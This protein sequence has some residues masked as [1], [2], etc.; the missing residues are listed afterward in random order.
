[1]RGGQAGGLLQA[2]ALPGI[3]QHWQQMLDQR[4]GVLRVP[5]QGAHQAWVVEIGQGFVDPGA[6]RAQFGHQARLHVLEAGQRLPFYVI[7]QAGAQRLAIDVQCQQRL[8]VACRAYGR[9][10]QPLPAQVSQRRML[11]LQFHL[12]I[13]AVANL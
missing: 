4:L 3:L 7:E 5:L 2:G 10:R 8:A 12:G 9:Y 1:M 13:I 11:R 6:Q